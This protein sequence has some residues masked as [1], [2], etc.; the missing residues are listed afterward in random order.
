MNLK[1]VFYL[2]GWILNVEAVL[3]LLPCATAF[4]YRESAGFSFV[5][6]ALGMLLLGIM[7]TVRKPK[8]KT[9]YAKEGFVVVAL[10]WI[11]LSIAGALPFVISGEI[12]SFTDALFETVSGF[13]TT[14][15]SILTDVDSL[16]RCMLM[17][18]SF[19][20][21]IGGMGVLVFMLA[22]LPMVGG[23]QTIHLLRAES[24]GP[25]VSK[26]VPKLRDSASLLYIIYVMMTLV[27]LLLLIVTKM[28]L[29]DAITISFGT[30]GTG[31][32]AV[33]TD[34]MASYSVAHQ[35]IITIFMILFGVNFNV[36]FL[37]LMRKP[38][39]IFKNEEVRCYFII[40][41]LAILF[42]TLNIRDLY[43][44]AAEAFR[45]AAFQV[46]SIITTTGFA[47]ADFNLW[48][49]FSQ[50]VLVLLMF[51]GACAGSTGGG[52]KVSR[53]LVSGKAVRKELFRFIH[54]KTVRV[55]KLDGKKVE[56]ETLRNINIYLFAYALIFTASILLVSLDNLDFS[57]TFTA[58]TA[59]FNNIGPGLG[60]VG[61]MSN[62]SALSDLSKYVMIFDMLAGRLEVF[63][64]LLLFV[65]TTWKRQ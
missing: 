54:P 31:G 17:W 2:L 55:L 56:H 10:G 52:I 41:G 36:Y 22:I 19:T 62:Y 16:S 9:F 14:G 58:V 35:T 4:I 53:I 30:A 12:P 28:P 7:L 49:L 61:P 51:I 46:A 32:F 45:Q 18:R 15:A 25:I 6:V 57:S 3:M 23:G 60:A 64:L 43:P 59:T 24:P 48:P 27:Q 37:L 34:G 63:P 1:M 42:I 26:L 13:T 44:T 21:W 47:T 40:I 11:I 33:H 8:K 20:H 39:E 65:P 38:K 50:M 29:F 5:W